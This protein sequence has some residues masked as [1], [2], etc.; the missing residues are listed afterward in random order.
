MLFS[1]RR[2]TP[3]TGMRVSVEGPNGMTE[4]ELEESVLAIGAAAAAVVVAVVVVVTDE[5]VPTST[6]NEDAPDIHDGDILVEGVEGVEG[7][8]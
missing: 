8:M 4:G 2:C 7:V 3:L 1:I 5:L 6:L